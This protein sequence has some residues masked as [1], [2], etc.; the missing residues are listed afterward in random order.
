LLDGRVVSNKYSRP[1][2]NDHSTDAEFDK[3]KSKE[4]FWK[5]KLIEKSF[6]LYIFHLSHDTGT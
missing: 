4:K 6:M 5:G 1:V 3:T 2:K